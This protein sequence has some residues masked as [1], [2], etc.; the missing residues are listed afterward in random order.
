M[1]AETAFFDYASSKDTEQNEAAATRLFGNQ[2]YEFISECIFFLY[3]IAHYHVTLWLDMMTI[4]LNFK[5]TLRSLNFNV[6]N[7]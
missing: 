4:C 5:R 2:S 1:Y 6:W 3:G 7:V